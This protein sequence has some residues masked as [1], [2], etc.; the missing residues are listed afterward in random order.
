MSKKVV[1][2]L[3]KMGVRGGGWEKNKEIYVLSFVADLAGGSGK[4]AG[5]VVAAYNE[6]LPNL[7]PAI[8]KDASLQFVLVSVSNLFKRIR[9]DQ[10][11]SLTGS[12]VLLYPN[13]DPKGLLASHFAIVECDE[14]K[15]K[16]GKLLEGILGDDSVKK[17]V[18]DLIKA[19]ISQTAVAGLMSAL[20]SN[21][22]EFL[23]K[24]KDDLLFAH[25]HSGFDFDNYGCGPE[26]TFQEFEIG[27]D[28][29]HCTLRVMLTD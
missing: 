7:L 13:L 11:V 3:P 26:S 8:M 23:K 1:L 20:V 2:S 5:D 17:G 28:R 16:L 22:P 24:N 15:R 21:I 4:K 6:T 19:G 29:A 18:A 14:G 9:P 10:P 27:N 25:S 12:G